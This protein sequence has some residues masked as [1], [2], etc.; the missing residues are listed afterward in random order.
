MAPQPA[1]RSRWIAVLLLLAFFAQVATAARETSITLDEPLHIASGY[2][3]LLTG[4]YRLVEEHPPLLKMLQAAPLL[5]ANP[6][7]QDPRT[8]S[9]WASA[10]LIAV[11][12]EI[13]VAY[14]PLDPL[15]YAARVPT[16]LVGVLLGALIYRWAADLVR[17]GRKGWALLALTLFSFDPNMLAHAA[18]AATD[19]GAAAGIVGALFAF[20][21][22]ARSAPDPRLGRALGAAVAL[23]IALGTKNTALMLGPVAAVLLVRAWP[24]ARATRYLAQ[25]GLIVAGAF[26]VLWATYRFEIGPVAGVPFPVPAASHALPL[27][28]LRE[29]MR[30]GH[31]A[32]LLGRNYHH[33][34]WRYFPI[35]LALKT[36]PLTLGLGLLSAALATA[37]RRWHRAWSVAG[38]SVWVFPVLYFATSLVSGINIG[39]RHLLPVLPFAYV[40]IA[41]SLSAG[42]PVPR[43]ARRVVRAVLLV[44]LGGYALITL[45]LHPWHL[46]Y[47]NVFAGGPD[48]GYRYLVD[49]NLDWGQTWKA[50]R[51]Y[52][53]GR[54]ITN[55]Y[56]SSYTINDP[57]AYGLDYTPLPPWPEAPPVFPQR[58]N[59]P[60]GVYAISSTQLQGVVVADPEMFDAFRKL[61]PVARIGHALFV[62]EVGT[63]PPIEWVAQCAAPAAPLPVEALREGFGMGLA[64]PVLTFDCTQSWIVPRGS[65][66][67]VLPR[68]VGHDWALLK[69]ARLAYEQTRT[70][71]VP[72]YTIYEWRALEPAAEPAP[73]VPADRRVTVGEVLAFVG[74]RAPELAAGQTSVVEAWWRIE[75]LPAG[76]LSLMAHL[77]GPDGTVVAVG[78]A[79][80]VPVDQW[81][82]GGLLIQRHVL[83]IPA[84]AAPGDYAL[85]LGAYTLPDIG[86]LPVTGGESPEVDSLVAGV[87]EVTAP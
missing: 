49:S 72:P 26:L 32:F 69:Q 74:Y 44:L 82:P 21:R 39:Y 80:G 20:W 10:D 1:R 34:D 66:R 25:A 62:Y 52:L 47:F 50:L 75:D 79:L 70:G 19:L 15:V 11:A 31:S 43:A 14:R 60:P 24:R 67:Y 64:V 86:R 2:A 8:S 87:L 35:A 17:H 83:A 78:D 54:G 41:A 6:P 57:H 27:I 30:E 77:V 4:D 38:L 53:D 37:T 23:G 28:R 85:H 73:Q 81:T 7:L 59:P 40:F 13:V 42:V 46:A 5:L 65:G 3:C 33:G 58:Y 55:F 9:G 63:S 56:L 51:K 16:M 22:W 36:P 68:T 12:R 29:H 76:P 71:W 18:V 45:Q 61:E 84:G 48:G